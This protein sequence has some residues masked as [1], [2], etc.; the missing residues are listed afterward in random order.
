[1]LTA[2]QLEPAD[3]AAQG[4]DV[5][6][7]PTALVTGSNGGVG[8]ALARKLASDGWRVLLHGRDPEKLARAHRGLGDP[9]ESLRADLADLGAV[10]QLAGN[11]REATDRLDAL[12]HNA[13]LV[14][15]TLTR[16][17]AG[18]ETTMAVNAL[19]PF[20]LTDALRPLLEA[21]ATAH[22]GAR[23]VTVSSEAHKGG[24]ASA[25]SDL[26]NGPGD[27][28]SSIKAY[29]QSKLVAT[30]WTLELARRLDETGVTA[31]ACHPGVVRTGCS[32]ASAARSGSWRRRS[33]SFY[34][35][36]SKGAESPYLLA[37]APA[38]GTRTGRFV[39][40]GHVRG[41]HEADP[42]A[43]AASPV[44]GAAVWGRARPAGGGSGRVTL[45][46]GRAAGRG[47]AGQRLC[48]EAV[49]RGP[50]PPSPPSPAM[51]PVLLAAA[52]LA[53]TASAP[54]V[55]QPAAE[56]PV[57]RVILFTSGVGYFEHAGRVAGDADVTLR[58]DEA[59]L[60]DVLKSLVVEDR[61]GRV[62]GVVY[63]TQAPVERTLRSFAIDLSGGPDLAAVLRQVRGAE[64]IVATP[65]G[66]VRGTVLAVGEQPRGDDG[67]A[68]E[69]LTLATDAGLVTVRLDTARR[70]EFV[71]P[72]LQAELD[73]A[74]DA[75]AEARGG[76]RKPV[77]VQFRGGG[78]R[79]V[80]LGY[81]VEA[82]VWKTSYRL[83]LPE[84]G[85]TRAAVGALQGWALVENPTEADW[86]NVDLTLVSGR[87]V[88]FVTD[89][90][91][92]RYVDRPV[93]TLDDDAVVRPETY[94]AGVGG[95]ASQVSVRTGGP[96]GTIS[97]TVRDA[98]TG[99]PLPG[100]N[101][102]VEGTGAG[103]ATDRDGRFQIGVGPG[104]YT[105][106]VSFIGY[107]TA[108]ETVRLAGGSGRV[109]D[110][111]LAAAGELSEVAVTALSG[112]ASGAVVRSAPAA[113]PPPPPLDPT[114]GVVAQGEAGDFGELFAYRLGEVTLPRRGSAMLPIVAGPVEAERL[115]VY[116]G[117]GGAA[118]DAGRPPG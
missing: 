81:V 80:R 111:R 29:A 13:G 95:G 37:T 116:T 106:A 53:A 11:V 27:G 66:P 92:P 113:A 5:A 56:V 16:T 18:V 69:V 50:D 40:R 44:F 55:A 94:A 12:V 65:D 100:A 87:P 75:L 22:G 24:D 108:R 64:V 73:A 110:A 118:P 20:V 93:V 101:V 90:Y 109:L 117:R 62:A 84:A 60:N 49:S 83:V 71:D 38:Y 114:A 17:G 14:S 52:L 45:A 4:A 26:L 2:P 96:A 57:E 31:N 85:A 82:P 28:Y 107:A 46:G 32:A 43:R 19:A 21:T 99:E 97:G 91:T 39:T 77:R 30:A 79:P 72:S 58:F 105:V 76:E 35:P 86:T 98:E 63:P 3:A 25:V 41:P 51:R 1:M 112:R 104:T 23:V 78:A 10:R 48:L 70:I 9:H 42:P 33:R 88:S 36:P 54:L 8:L 115:S 102:R 34:L 103:A 68:V 89:L 74:L 6:D 59:A 47:P 7:R 67:A 15:P 61:A